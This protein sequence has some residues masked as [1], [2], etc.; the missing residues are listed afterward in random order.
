MGRGQATLRVWVLVTTAGRG[1]QSALSSEKGKCGLICVHHSGPWLTLHKQWPLIMP[2]LL[3]SLLSLPLG[4]FLL[5]GVD[6]RWPPTH[7]ASKPSPIFSPSPYSA[8]LA[9]HPLLHQLPS[10]CL[11]FS[12]GSPR[13]QQSLERVSSR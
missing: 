6:S 5:S 11:V 4:T 9:V 12:S 2:C 3:A 1:H 8:Q 10:V 13:A 7:R